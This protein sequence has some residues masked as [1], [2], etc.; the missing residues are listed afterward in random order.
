MTAHQ[1]KYDVVLSANN[2]ETSIGYMLDRSSPESDVDAADS[3]PLQSSSSESSSPAGVYGWKDQRTMPGVAIGD[4]RGGQGQKVLDRADA[5]PT[6]FRDGRH[7]ACQVEGEVSLAPSFISVVCTGLEDRIYEA[8]GR[9]FAAFHPTA[10]GAEQAQPASVKE[11]I[12]Y[13]LILASAV[14]ADATAIVVVDD[15]SEYPYVAADVD[16]GDWL[17]DFE[18]REIL[19]VSAGPTDENIAVTRNGG[20]FDNI[21]GVDWTT[22]HDAGNY[23]ACYGWRAI[24]FDPVDTHPNEHFPYQ[25]VQS[26]TYDGEYL[27]AAFSDGS[28]S[29]Y[30]S[31]VWRKGPGAAD[32]FEL[33]IQNIPSIQQICYGFGSLYYATTSVAG[34]IGFD[35]D[36]T[37]IKT[38]QLSLK[39]VIDQ[40]WTDTTHFVDVKINNLTPALTSCGLVMQGP[41][42]YW[43][44]SAGRRSWLYRVQSPV[45]FE[46]VHEFAKGFKATCC[47]SSFGN[48]YVGGYYTRK[49]G[50][51]A[52]V[53]SYEGVVY[54]MREGV[55]ERILTIDLEETGIDNR[56]KGISVVGELLQITSN[57][58]VYHY[59]VKSA[60]WW[61]SGDLP[62]KD[63]ATSI[64][65]PASEAWDYTFDMDALPTS[66]A[67]NWS[68]LSQSTTPP[69]TS[70]GTDLTS[71]DYLN[72]KGLNGRFIRYQYL[73]DLSGDDILAQLTLPKLS[74]TQFLT[75]QR[76][77][78]EVSVGNG[79]HEAR[80]RLTGLVDA[81]GWMFK[82]GMGR[83]SKSH[84]RWRFEEILRWPALDYTFNFQVSAAGS[85]LWFSEPVENVI[86]RVPSMPASLLKTSTD[87]HLWFSCG[88][89]IGDAVLYDSDTKKWIDDED[90]NI[91]RTSDFRTAIRQLRINLVN[92]SPG[93][94]LQNTPDGTG[95]VAE[96]DGEVFIPLLGSD[97]DPSML[98]FTRT[99]ERYAGDGAYIE[100]SDSYQNMGTANKFY[101]RFELAYPTLYTGQS[102]I[103]KAIIDDQPQTTSDG[104]PSDLPIVGEGADG[105]SGR[106]S[107]MSYKVINEN[108]IK[109]RVLVTLK[110]SDH[111]RDKRDALRI[112]SIAV[113][114][115]PSSSPLKRMFIFNCIDNVECRDG[116]IWDVDAGDAVDFVKQLKKSGMVVTV[117]TDEG[118][119][120]AI[121]DAYRFT[122]ST[123]D[124][125]MVSTKQG[126]LQVSLRVVD[127]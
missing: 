125:N 35:T 67:Q 9:I 28:G 45:G 77:A 53:D 78:L 110:D 27:Y 127:E 29:G 87:R 59:S 94:F 89:K 92:E 71:V 72:V 81:S 31:T 112:N 96:L 19:R 111:L 120:S 46:L 93:Q 3:E 65:P 100:T 60:G 64:A 15:D 22:V 8:G 95:P 113:R 91:T 104:S 66:D 36:G 56:I 2:G 23:L 90:A 106:A 41:W 13:T 43:L 50:V 39:K 17:Y 88:I 20:V 25:H 1:G 116:S 79:T 80:F 83:W 99:G 44:I 97:G 37:T 58:N 7:I 26:M 109:S 114:F 24:E 6:A 73:G 68:V 85:S 82:V 86:S 16:A 63:F 117:G 119:I 75:L 55:A 4:F 105:Q 101:R 126:Q 32:K 118:N 5:S 61:H 10:E 18:Q 48:V 121:V 49:D 123:K 124:E 51:S 42:C 115:M 70:I 98:A 62:P 102:I 69:T 57:T 30:A 11:L 108:G 107:K 12:R 84:S 76:R 14:A 33:F 122:R 74:L 103:G 54:L 47:E 40:T 52:G 21:E 34:Y 38:Y